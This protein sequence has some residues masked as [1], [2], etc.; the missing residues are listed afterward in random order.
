MDCEIDLI[1]V[2]RS[3]MWV[4]V[5]ESMQPV[6]CERYGSDDTIWAARILWNKPNRLAV[7]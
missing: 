7:V 5:A 2:S 3:E 4:I 1:P 6:G